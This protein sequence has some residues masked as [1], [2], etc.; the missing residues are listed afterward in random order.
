[1]RMELDQL[2]NELPER[3]TTLRT[4]NK[5]RFSFSHRHAAARTGPGTADA[6]RQG[7]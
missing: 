4:E 5:A 2:V 6:K 1:M 7:S 3:K